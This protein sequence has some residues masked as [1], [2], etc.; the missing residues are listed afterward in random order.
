LVIE[1]LSPG[2]VNETRDKEVKLKLYSRR[3]VIEYWILDWPKKLIEVYRREEGIS[4]SQNTYG[5][6]YLTVTTVARIR[7]QTE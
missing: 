1:A 3:G 2:V 7:V 5:A 4:H 6:R